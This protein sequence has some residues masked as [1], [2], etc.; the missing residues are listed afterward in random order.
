M[1]DLIA[2]LD[3]CNTQMWDQVSDW[4]LQEGALQGALG[5]LGR[6]ADGLALDDPRAQSSGKPDPT[7]VGKAARAAAASF[8]N[9][10][11]VGVDAAEKK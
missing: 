8:I 2:L 5:K 7:Q 10:A 4:D 1:P 11:D 3:E 9:S 6:K